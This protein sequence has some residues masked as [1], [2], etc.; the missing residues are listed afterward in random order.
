MQVANRTFEKQYAAQNF[1][2][3]NMRFLPAKQAKFFKIVLHGNAF[4]KVI[5]SKRRFATCTVAL[6]IYYNDLECEV[7]KTQLKR[8]KQIK[9]YNTMT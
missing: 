1:W 5:V 7:L 9:L 3:A 4:F 6:C 2:R 8:A